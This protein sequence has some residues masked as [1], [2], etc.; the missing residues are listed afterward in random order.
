MLLSCRG[1][2]LSLCMTVVA[3]AEAKVHPMVALLHSLVCYAWLASCSCKC[4]QSA[5]ALAAD[6]SEAEHP[7]QQLPLQAEHAVLHVQ[8]QTPYEWQQMLVGQQQEEAGVI[9][10]QRS[11]CTLLYQDALEPMIQ[12]KQMEQEGVPKLSHQQHSQQAFSRQHQAASVPA[13]LHCNEQTRQL[14][15]LAPERQSTTLTWC[16]ISAMRTDAQATC[17]KLALCAITLAALPFVAWLKQP[18]HMRQWACWQD[19]LPAAI[20]ATHAS[21][22]LLVGARCRCSVSMV[23]VPSN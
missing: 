16:S 23:I 3:L 8:Q 22:C 18:M 12:H 1:A 2:A 10:P 14:L 9:A 20:V 13:I 7:A 15:S 21:L 17:L 4:Q 6:Q 11:P 5:A 19:A